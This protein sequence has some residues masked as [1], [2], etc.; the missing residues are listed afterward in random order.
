MSLEVWIEAFPW[1]S[2]D[3]KKGYLG[4]IQYEKQFG[5]EPTPIDPRAAFF[6]QKMH[7]AAEYWRD[8]LGDQ[9]S[10]LQG[11]IVR[12]KAEMARN[13]GY[14]ESLLWAIKNQTLLLEQLAEKKR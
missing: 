10:G 14:V 2:E 6:I 12:L 3:Q 7:E 11:E 4:L 5:L 8:T 9:V 1:E 13:E